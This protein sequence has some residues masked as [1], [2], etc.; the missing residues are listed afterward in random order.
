MKYHWRLIALLLIFAS[1][2]TPK[3]T[4]QT[5]AEVLYKEAV[6][7]VEQERFLMA[8]EKLNT[9]KTQYP[10]SYFATNAELLQADIHYAQENFIEAASAYGLFKDFHP[11]HEQ[12]EYVLW[13]LAESHFNQ[14]PSTFDR[15]LSM[16]YEAIKYYKELGEKYPQSSWK[17]QSLE[18]IA[19]LE[20]QLKQKELYIADFYFRTHVYASAIYRYQQILPKFSNDIA[21]TELAQIRLMAASY[22][23]EDKTQCL[24]YAKEFIPSN[25][26]QLEAKLLHYK[27]L[28]EQLKDNVS[29]SEN[30]GPKH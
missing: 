6:L 7:L 22:H 25:N 18:R 4:G 23:L 12:I 9:I 16:A 8:S 14:M 24:D 21:T 11:K 27:S 15:D 13:R 2:S 10:Y 20:H 19:H 26:N 30:N 17:E 1:C 28:C 5:S 3:P 29:I